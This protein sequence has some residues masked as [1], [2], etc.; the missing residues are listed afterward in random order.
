MPELIFQLLP[1]ALTPLTAL[2]PNGIQRCIVL[3]LAALYFGGFVVLPNIPSVRLKKLEQYIEETAKIHAIAVQ[4]LDKDPRFVTEMSLRL[5]QVKL[6]ESFLRTKTFNGKNVAWKRYAQYLRGLF[7]HI[8]DCQKDVHGIRMSMLMALECN[9]Q[10][11]YTED[12]AQR[13]STLDTAF[14]N[15]VH[16]PCTYV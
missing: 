13:Q 4:E 1:L 12:I 8:G 5:A 14:A 3:A 2:V 11:R 7:F 15:P 9:R 10:R 16:N 6:S